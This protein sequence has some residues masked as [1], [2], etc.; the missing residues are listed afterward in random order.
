MQC[1]VIEKAGRCSGEIVA[2]EVCEK[3]QAWRRGNTGQLGFNL[4]VKNEEKTLE[5]MSS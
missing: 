5:K 3:H 4:I 1:A 2:D